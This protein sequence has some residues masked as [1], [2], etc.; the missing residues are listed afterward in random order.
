MADKGT[1]YF[2]VIHN[3]RGGSTPYQARVWRGGKYVYLG[4]FVTAEEAALS[5]R[6]A[7]F[8]LKL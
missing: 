6:R 3:P 8:V 4:I 7:G 2:G 5:V 1:G